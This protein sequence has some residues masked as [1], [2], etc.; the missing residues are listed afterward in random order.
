MASIP[1]KTHPTHQ[2]DNELRVELANLVESLTTSGATTLDTEKMK[3]L[4]KICKKSDGYVEYAYQQLM[5][6]LEEEHSE[7]RLSAF[8]VMNELF[9]R[10]HHFRE[11]LVAD[12]Q[13]FL[14][15]TVE[16]DVDYPL[17]PPKA[18][19]RLLKEQSL[20][21]IAAWNDKF[22]KAYKKLAVGYNFLRHCKQVN[23]NS[24][25]ARL[26][27]EQEREQRREEQEQRMKRERF[28]TAVQEM[29]EVLPEIEKCLRE[30]ESCYDILFPKN[31]FFTMEAE[32][33]LFNKEEENSNLVGKVEIDKDKTRT[34]DET[35]EQILQ[36]DGAKMGSETTIEK[37]NDTCI[38]S[39]IQNSPLESGVA[40]RTLNSEEV[41]EN[42][43]PNSLCNVKD[44]KEVNAE[45]L[46]NGNKSLKAEVEEEEGEEESDE[47]EDDNMEDGEGLDRKGMQSHGVRSLV[48]SISIDVEIPTEGVMLQEDENNTDLLSALD[49]AKRLLQVKY[50]PQLSSWIQI[51]VEANKTETDFFKKCLDMQTSLTDA[52]GK[53]SDLKIKRMPKM[54]RVE[55]GES[56]SEDDFEEVPEKEGYEPVIAE[57]LREEYGLPSLDK[58]SPETSK[59]ASASAKAS[60][61]SSSQMSERQ[62]PDWNPL[63]SCDHDP[64][65][66]TSRAAT[67]AVWKKQKETVE[68]S[69]K[70][71]ISSIEEE[72][73][74]L[75]EADGEPSKVKREDSELQSKAPVIPY[76]IDLENWES[77]GDFKAPVILRPQ[78][79]NTI[80]ASSV[81]EEEISLENAKEHI[82]SRVYSFTGKF[83]PVKWT[84]RAPLPSGKLCERMDRLKCPFHGKII[85]RDEDGKPSNPEDIPTVKKED[86]SDDDEMP[87]VDLAAASSSSW[88][89]PELLR[90]IE[91]A[92][93]LNLQ[94]KRGRKKGSEKEEGDKKGKGKRG[95][96]GV[97]KYPGLTDLTEKT[98]TS[99]T[100]L[101]KRVFN[102]SAMK[103]VNAKLSAI[104]NRRVRDKFSNQF[105]YALKN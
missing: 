93:G 71:S 49:D 40:E 89:D 12:M 68:S 72:Q 34:S 13:Q 67:L 50:L 62:H 55:K 92:T 41:C 17:P 30:T 82:A 23:F 51:F 33:D 9:Q 61:S 31:S 15:L 54:R 3:Q 95:K 70:R 26:N 102:K 19:A 79:D 36:K 8:Q 63:L 56:D 83:E 57:H 44:D 53:Y 21:A 78:T 48:Q 65:D 10:S 46:E 104:D 1:K 22:G 88:Q 7:I 60:S 99:R 94:V 64:K 81:Q 29:T 90:D 38:Q 16:T 14:L 27:A 96:K 11:L 85:P 24:I 20:S 77:P 58:D 28:S 42:E 84:C 75:Q 69:L 100:R 45:K 39:E 105:H 97:K 74:E 73:S 98:N 76:G 66:P 52:L 86:M 32:A 43:E 103:R 25:T 35:S 101:E 59:K 37:E 47:D 87:S 91:A 18:A 80:W 2:L 5:S 6:Q 4:K